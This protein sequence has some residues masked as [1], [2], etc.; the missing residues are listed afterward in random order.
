MRTPGIRLVAAT[1]LVIVAGCSTARVL[2]RPPGG[3]AQWPFVLTFW[4]GPPLVEFDD[5]RAAEIAAADFTVVGPPC[6]GGSDPA[7]NVH[8]LDVARQT[9]CTCG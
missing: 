4:C 8:A 6:Q 1:A 9:A 2:D 7:Q 3:A 5:A